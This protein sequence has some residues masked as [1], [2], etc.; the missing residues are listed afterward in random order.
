[1]THSL[2][3]N[4]IIK[5]VD[6]HMTN[7]DFTYVS[8]PDCNF[9]GDLEW[10]YGDFLLEMATFWGPW[11]LEIACSGLFFGCNSWLFVKG[12]GCPKVN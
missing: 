5:F 6:F 9:L 4:M 11:N 10:T 1:M 7:G 8:L 3:L 2:L 12:D